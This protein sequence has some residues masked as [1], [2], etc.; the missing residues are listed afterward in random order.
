[1]RFSRVIGFGAAILDLAIDVPRIIKDAELGRP[2]KKEAME[3]VVSVAVSG[4][5][6]YTADYI[7]AA[8][9]VSPPGW[10]A[11]LVGVGGA[12][13]LNGLVN[14]AEHKSFLDV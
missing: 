13:V 14:L 6:G 4:A 9:V 10:V 3:D 12:V 1:M 2:W 8:L 5:G 11:I 7:L